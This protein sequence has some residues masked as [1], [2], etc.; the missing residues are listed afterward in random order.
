MASINYG[1]KE[2]SVKIVYYGPGL[3][4]KTT[5]LQVIHQKSPDSKKSDMVSLATEKDRTIFFDFLP[6]SLG[7]IKGFNTKFQLYTVPGQVYYNS[8]R[9]LVLR[10][11]DGVVFV[12]DSSPDAQ[13][14]NLQSMKNLMENLKEHSYTL[15]DIAAV[16][17][18]NKRDLP[19]ALDIPT[20]E[21]SLNNKGFASIEAVAVQGK[22]VFETLKLIGKQVIELLNK[23]YGD[24]TTGEFVPASGDTSEDPSSAENDKA[25]QT[26]QAP[27]MNETASHETASAE[28]PPQ[29]VP[30]G[31]SAEHKSDQDE[32][33]ELSDDTATYVN[34]NDFNYSEDTSELDMEIQRYQKEIEENK[35][36]NA[37]DTSQQPSSA[38]DSQSQPTPPSPPHD[39]TQQET[40]PAQ[41]AATQA[42]AQQPENNSPEKKTEQNALS[43][44]ADRNNEDTSA[45]FE[46]T[47]TKELSGTLDTQN[48]EKKSDND[49]EFDGED[50]YYFTTSKRKNKSKGFFSR[51]FGK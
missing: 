46:I 42:P 4:G 39:K 43:A 27:T 14:E 44:P 35:W 15:K 47:D 50:T 41:T 7:Q 19:D 48:D 10:G 36:K 24:T 25:A 5:N 18:Y 49:E 40:T 8:T 21:S 1:A 37:T 34:E 22:G 6:L 3:S 17:Q 45:S 12:A 11:V 2:I 20:L 26:T 9:K 16:I 28:Q 51:L 30:E 31:E 32:G 38:A 23:K 29:S 33:I 13:Q